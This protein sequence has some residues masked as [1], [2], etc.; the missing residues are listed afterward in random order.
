M[1]NINRL[2]NVT[3]TAYTGLHCTLFAAACA[4]QSYLCSFN[5]SCPGI[6]RRQFENAYPAKSGPAGIEKN[7][8]HSW[9]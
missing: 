9:F 6:V 3:I 1:Y 7:P 8:V 4:V 5:K 2:L